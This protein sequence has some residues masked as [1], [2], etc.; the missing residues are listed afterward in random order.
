MACAF[1]LFA[2]GLL[3]GCTQKE[4]PD[5]A[6]CAATSYT[7]SI[8]A[9]VHPRLR[10]SEVTRIVENGRSLP[11]ADKVD[12]IISMTARRRGVLHHVVWIVHVRGQFRDQA[13][14]VVDE[15]SDAELILNDRT[16]A[17]SGIEEPR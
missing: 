15:F 7:V 11:A 16:G 5:A 12:H 9:S 2:T 10:P 17:I 6:A 14:N 8:E 4:C 1:A 3:T 13:R